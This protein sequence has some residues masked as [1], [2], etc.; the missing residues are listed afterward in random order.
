MIEPT[1]LRAAL[2]PTCFRLVAKRLKAT[3]STIGDKRGDTQLSVYWH[4]RYLTHPSYSLGNVHC[5]GC[6]TYSSF[7]C[8]SIASQSNLALLNRNSPSDRCSNNATSPTARSKSAQGITAPSPS[9]HQYIR[10]YFVNGR[11]PEPGTWCLPSRETFDWQGS[12]LTGELA[13]QVHYDLYDDLVS[14]AE[15]LVKAVTTFD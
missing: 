4:S 6:A 12:M 2:L 9:T 10:E 1:S 3:E 8:I 14:V 5:Y 11:L 13:G 15:A 7:G